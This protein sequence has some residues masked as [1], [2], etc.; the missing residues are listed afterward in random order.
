MKDFIAKDSDLTGRTPKLTCTSLKDP[1]DLIEFKRI[2][3]EKFI[4]N[5][6]ISFVAYSDKNDQVRISSENTISVTANVYITTFIVLYFLLLYFYARLINMYVKDIINPIKQITYRIHR[7]LKNL[8]RKKNSSKMLPDDIVIR[9]PTEIREVAENF[10]N[11]YK[12]MTIKNIFLNEM[13]LGEKMILG[14]QKVIHNKVTE[15]MLENI[16]EAIE[17]IPYEFES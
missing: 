9:E 15:K 1:E 14:K 12:K 16:K 11:S 2:L 3:P 13:E 8:F 4:Q 10:S 17:K 6:S 5:S 7:S